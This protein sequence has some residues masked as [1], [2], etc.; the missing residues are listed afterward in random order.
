MKDNMLKSDTFRKFGFYSWSKMMRGAFFNA[1]FRPVF[2]LRLCQKTQHGPLK[3]LHI[4]FKILHRFASHLAGIEL[5]SAT[6]IGAGFVLTHGR[7][8]V[9]NQGASI[10]RNVT[11][12]H[13][14][15]LGQADRI[16]KD[17]S[18]LTEFPTIE[19]DT[20]IGPHAIIVG[21]VTIGKGSRIAG[22]AFV[23]D[24]IP[25]YSLVIGNP[26]KIVKSNCTPDVTNRIPLEDEDEVT[27][28]L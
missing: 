20:W 8:V 22:G 19:D 17:G 18:R 6:Q 27:S 13:G 3:L 12:F 15:T 26:A 16:A 5:P 23:T 7:G 4:P 14:V 21:G 1:T 24:D 11:L 2:T 25:A 9:I 28:S 10:G